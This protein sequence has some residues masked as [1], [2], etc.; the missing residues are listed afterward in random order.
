MFCALNA[1]ISIHIV[2]IQKKTSIL[3]IR[4]TYFNEFIIKIFK[5]VSPQQLVHRTT[6]LIFS[7]KERPPV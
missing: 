5:E 3:R 2:V 1:P 6:D 7:L 4:F